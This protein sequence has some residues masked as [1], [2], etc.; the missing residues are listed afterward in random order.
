V[1]LFSVGQRTLLVDH[2]LHIHTRLSA[3][4]CDETA[5]PENIIARAAERG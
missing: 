1:L 5:T 4:S 2:D 3:C